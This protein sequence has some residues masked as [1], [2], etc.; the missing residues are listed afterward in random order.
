MKRNHLWT[1]K[2]HEGI[3]QGDQV[4]PPRDFLELMGEDRCCVGSAKHLP[5]VCEIDV[6]PVLH[7]LRTEAEV[8]EEDLVVIDSEVFRLHISVEEATPMQVPERL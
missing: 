8:D 4:I 5:T 2:L 1:P 3:H 7:E 6:L